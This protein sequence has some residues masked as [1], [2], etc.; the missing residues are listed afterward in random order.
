VIR[1]EVPAEP[2]AMPRP[3]VA[4]RGGR[5]HGYVPSHASEAM[6]QVR[7]CALAALGDQ[8]PLSG[9]LSVDIVAW[10][11]MP[12]NIP[13]RDRLTARPVKRP[14]LDNLLKLVLDGCSPLW[15]DDSQVVELVA[16]KRY[17]IDGPPRWD[18]AVEALG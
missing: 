10:V 4:V 2:V 5:A 1:F 8:A 13:R 6:W 14:D 7:Q 17:A 18:I 15:Q 9:P 12:A 11:R 3:R 16:R